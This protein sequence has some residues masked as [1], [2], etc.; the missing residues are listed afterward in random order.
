M[1][2]TATRRWP[3]LR[4]ALVSHLPFI[5]LLWVPFTVLTLAVPVFIEMGG[6]VSQSAMHYAATQLPRW[7]MFGLALDM[8]SNTLRMHLAHGRTRREFVRQGLVDCVIM[9][10]FAAVLITLG[11]LAE[12][13]FYAMFGWPQNLNREA[14]FATADDYPAILGTFWLLFLMWTM[15]GLVIGLGFFHSSGAGLLTI[16]IGLVIA[17]PTVILTGNSGFPVIGDD[18]VDLGL[19]EGV[20]LA[21]NGSLLVVAVGIVWALAR[22]VPMKSKAP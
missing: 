10:G 21:L 17:L 3:L 19:S 12:R 4:V 5:A 9:S 11:Y 14:L 15:A 16:P 20:L 1:T 18:L 2:T 6:T 13:G 22:H 7:L 8:V